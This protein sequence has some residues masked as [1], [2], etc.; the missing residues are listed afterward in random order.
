MVLVALVLPLLPQATFTACAQDEVRTILLFQV[1]DESSSGPPELQRTATDSLQMA[2]DAVSGMECTEFSPS[3]A[4]VRRAVAEGKILPTQ[5]ETGA[6][7][8]RTAISIGYALA[9]DT[10]V[11]A[12]IQSYRSTQK[13]REVDVI[14]SGQAYDVKQNYDVESGEPVAKPAVA[15][16]FGVVGT[17]GTL[18]GY[19]GSDRPLAREAIEDASYRIAK[20][21]GGASISEVAKPKPKARKKSSVTK[22]LAIAAVVGLLAWAVSSSGNDGVAGPS[23]DAVPPT[24]LPL[25]AEGTDTIRVRWNPPT[26]TTWTILRYELQRSVDGGTWSWFGPG[27]ASRYIDRTATEYPDFDV[28][29]GHS[30]RY[31]I[32]AVYTNSKY[33]YWAAFTGVT[34]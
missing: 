11:V 20:V 19:R 21:L 28:S 3:S 4:L 1:T 8:P 22:W 13:Q 27:N 16:A 24:P 12:S 25:Q 5:L 31:Q 7:D 23:A 26:G 32:R 34:L 15:Q 17:S 30:Y 6:S 2:I 33:S 14:L 9:V 10:V 29:A 18:P